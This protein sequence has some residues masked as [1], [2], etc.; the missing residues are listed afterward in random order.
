MSILAN[1]SADNL[2]DIHK[3]VRASQVPN[4][5]GFQIN[6]TSL[7]NIEA[8]EEVLK[9]YWDK[10]LLFLIRYGFLLDFD[11]KFEAD[12]QCNGKNNPSAIQFPSH[13]KTY[14]KE[15]SEYK[16][17]LGPFTQPPICPLNISPF[18]TREKQGSQN[19]HIIIDLSFSKGHAVNSNI[20]KDVY[21]QSQAAMQGFAFIQG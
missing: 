12:L 20:S 16:A 2:L 9:D 21:G 8:W 17:I 1:N 4:S 13:V 10:K 15:E 11:S 18:L 6:A 19:R 5:L 7:L 3:R 14:L